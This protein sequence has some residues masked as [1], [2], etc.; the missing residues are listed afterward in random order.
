MHTVNM[1]RNRVDHDGDADFDCSFY[2]HTFFISILFLF[3]FLCLCFVFFVN[4]PPLLLYWSKFRPFPPRSSLLN[5]N[6]SCA[7]NTF[8]FTCQFRTA[9]KH[10][11]LHKYRVF[12]IQSNENYMCSNTCFGRR[13]LFF[14]CSRIS[15]RHVV[16]TGSPATN[17]H[18]RQIS[19]CRFVFGKL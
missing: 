10:R 5:Q 3:L 9:H 7:S 19:K 13:F 2:K 8:T 6:Q 15:F 17:M 4:S 18:V 12:L 16:T 11:V 14:L 1:C